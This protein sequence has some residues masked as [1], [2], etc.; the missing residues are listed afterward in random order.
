[1]RPSAAN[2][3]ASATRDGRAG[4]KIFYPAPP[5]ATGEDAAYCADGRATSDGMAGLVGFRQLGLS[6]LLAHL[7]DAPSGCLQRR[8]DELAAGVGAVPGLAGL[9]KISGAFVGGHSRRPLGAPGGRRGD[10]LDG[11]VLHD[12]ALGMASRLKLTKPTV[13]WTS[14]EYDRGR[15]VMSLPTTTSAAPSKAAPQDSG[16]TVTFSVAKRS[17]FAATFFAAARAGARRCRPRLVEVHVERQ[18]EQKKSPIRRR[19]GR[20]VLGPQAVGLALGDVAAPGKVHFADA[21]PPAMLQRF[22]KATDGRHR[23]AD[24]AGSSATTDRANAAAS[25]SSGARVRAPEVAAA[26]LAVE[27]QRRVL[28]V[29]FARVRFVQPER[30][31]RRRWRSSCEDRPCAV[32]AALVLPEPREERVREGLGQHAPPQ[33]RGRVRGDVRVGDGGGAPRRAHGRWVRRQALERREREG[34]LGASST[35]GRLRGGE[36]VVALASARVVASLFV[37]AAA[38]LVGAVA[39][40][41]VAALFVSVGARGLAHISQVKYCDFVLMNVHAA[42]VQGPPLEVS[43]PFTRME[44]LEFASP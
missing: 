32:P 11:L 17:A 18:L 33:A 13:S 27:G 39:L 19:Q 35:R 12:P 6:F 20:R 34:F 44:T 31:R 23:A 15:Q 40:A 21:S 41:V 10:A 38:A 16:A 37:E 24:G 29:V 5:G 30:P 42:Q 3:R 7:A 9:P 25:S 28:V 36:A 26:L 4:A 22:P 8:S 2:S 43:M 14:D 1:M